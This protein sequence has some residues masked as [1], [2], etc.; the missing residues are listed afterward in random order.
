MSKCLLIQIAT[1][2]F[3][4]CTN[5][6]TVDNSNLRIN[7]SVYGNTR[8]LHEIESIRNEKK[9]TSVQSPRKGEKANSSVLRS[10]GDGTMLYGEVVYSNLMNVD[11]EDAI[12]WGLYSFP[13]QAN[14]TFTKKLIHNTI[15][16]NGGGTYRDGKLYFVSYYE[17]YEPGSLL[18]LY[19]CTLDLNT[20]HLDSKALM[21]NNFSSIGLDMTYDPVGDVIYSQTFPDNAASTTDYNFHLSTVNIETGLST[22][23]APLERMSMIACDVS[24]QLYGVRYNDGMLVKINKSDAT[25]TKVGLT[26]IDPQYN[27]SGT[28]DFETGKL[29]WTTVDRSNEESG[30][31]EIDKFTGKA[32]LI[33]YYPNDEQVTCLYIPQNADNCEL[34]DITSFTADYSNTSSTIGT[35]SMQAPST[36]IY[37]K[38]VEGNVTLY[39]YVDGSLKF[40]KLCAPGTTLI[41]ELDLLT[42]GEHH[43]EAIATHPSVGKSKRVKLDVWVGTDGAEAAPNFTLTKTADDTAL[44]TWDTPDKGEH[45]GQINPILVY[46]EIRRFPGNKLIS[47]DATGNSFTDKIQDESYKNYYYTIT[48]IHKGVKGGTA[49]SNSVGFGI[50][51]EI[52][53]SENFDTE[54][55]YK[56]YIVYNHNNDDGFWEYDTKN[57]CARYKYDTFNR[58]DDWLVTPGLNLG[59]EKTYKLRFK[60]RS[61]GRLYPEE[62]EVMLGDNSRV[63]DFK[64]TLIEHTALEH[65]EYREYEAVINVK[66]AGIYFVAFHAVTKKGQFHLYVDDVEIEFGPSAYSPSSVTNLNVEENNGILK[67]SFT[68]PKLNFEG[69]ELTELTSVKIFRNGNLIH[70][71][72]SPQINS[73]QTY[74]DNNPVSG[75]NTYKI[76]PVNSYGEGIPN[77]I[78]QTIGNDIPMPPTNVMQRTDNGKDAIISWEAPTEGLNGGKLP[79]TSIRY[80]V[81][82]NHNNLVA[83]NLSNTTYTDT[84]IDTQ[85]GQKTIYYRVEATTSLGSSKKVDSNFITYGEPYDGLFKESFANGAFMTSDWFM[86]IVEPSPY[87]NEFYSRYWGFQHSKYDRGPRPQD[88]N[89]DNGCLIAYTDFLNVESRMISPK[90]NVKELENPVFSFW[91]FHYYNADPMESYSHADETMDVEVYIDGEYVSMLKAPIRLID[92]N[93]WRRYDILLKDFVGK[94][95][96]Q[97]AF[98]AHNYLSYDQ[99]IDNITIYDVKLNDLSI[100]GFSMP[101]KISA[102]SVRPINATVYNNGVNSIKDY[103]IEFLRDGEVFEVVE[104]VKELKFSESR[105]Y[106][107]EVKPGINQAG[108]SFR[109]SA[110]AVFDGDDDLSNNMSEEIQSEV[111]TNT[112]PVVTTLNSVKQGGDVLLRWQEPDNAG[113]QYNFT[114][115]FE[116]YEA[117]IIDKIGEWTVADIDKLP[118]YTIQNSDSETGDYGYPNAGEP[119]AFQVFNPRSI[120]LTSPLWTPYL[121]EQMIICFDAAG[122]N[123]DW[124]ISPKVK[125]NTKVSFM[126]KSVTDLYG[127]E[128]FN[129]CYSSTDK[130]VKNFKKLGKVNIV[131]AGEWTKYEFELP[132]N[133][134]Y[135]AIQCVSENCYALLLDDISFERK[136][137]MPLSLYGFNIYRNEMKINTA[138]VEES[139]FVDKEVNLNQSKYNFNYNVTAVYDQGES[140]FSNT[141]NVNETGINSLTGKTINAYAV[142][143]TIFIENAMECNIQI[144]NAAGQKEIEFKADSNVESIDVMSGLHIIRI[145][146]SVIK[147]LIK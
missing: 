16:A 21:G 83:N 58:A 94:N 45:G 138:V 96:F 131:P 61:E 86:T 135:F 34:S 29:Y 140:L 112:L 13:A 84:S 39:L 88:Q 127:L 125:G 2:L 25:V 136:D 103:K 108:K 114:E 95:D 7:R 75:S 28:F 85:K 121:G 118:T 120:N 40:S 91:Y 24:G 141:S 27:G 17:G 46:Y 147:V 113:N 124:L 43:L 137:P 42:K 122:I 49:T 109:Y 117:F 18:Y 20:L 98:K 72:K 111:P 4:L 22:A 3:C 77:E 126:A 134:Q 68:T 142:N 19:F 60:A 104:D 48:S 9:S 143:S 41:E 62:L 50:P 44:L 66:K 35:I 15:C 93:G 51:T 107:I 33:S 8:M 82:D 80:N 64:T 31:Y 101:D 59:T 38:A 128:K 54:D 53:Y 146:N 110:R 36:D 69:T 26:G 76:I 115:S 67:L 89:G 56:T 52:P 123:D 81:Y 100:T 145:G 87:Q 65:D 23:I 5:A 132:N 92:G 129:F 116:S 10:Q 1:L 70:T 73:L 102:G 139:S 74:T 30:I 130:K 144:Y 133:A 6:Q 90:I 11:Q 57:Q 71:I 97:I 105:V 106:T 79:A 55:A 12:T 37:G 63:S 32:K 14:T 119:M 99:H 78:V 47:E